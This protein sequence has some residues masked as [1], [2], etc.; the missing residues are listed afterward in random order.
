MV[1]A[2]PVVEGRGCRPGVRDLITSECLQ[3]VAGEGLD[4]LPPVYKRQDSVTVQRDP[5]PPYMG[6]GAPNRADQHLV[7]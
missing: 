2:A 6:R 7:P 5:P 4:P 3:V 1:G